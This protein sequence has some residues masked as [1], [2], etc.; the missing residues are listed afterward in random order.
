MGAD[1]V[2]HR[3]RLDDARPADDRRNA[4]A[5]F[6]VRVLLAAEHGRAAVGPGEG[7]GAVVGRVHHDR[8]VLDAELLQLV[9]EFA[10]HPVVL[11]HA[12]GIDA[13]ARLAL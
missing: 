13:E 4:V 9:Q 7:L 8:V 2:D 3:A 6:P 1:I 5:A 10:D 11:D 12:V